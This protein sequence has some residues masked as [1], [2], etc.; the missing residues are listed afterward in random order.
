ME[1]EGEKGIKTMTRTLAWAT[2]WTVL[3]NIDQGK[4]IQKDEVAGKSGSELDF[5]HTEFVVLVG[6]SVGDVELDVCI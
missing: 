1:G 2:G 6:D 3:I 5:G 4:G